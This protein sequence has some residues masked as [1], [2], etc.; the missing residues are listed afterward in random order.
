MGFTFAQ[1]RSSRR[2]RATPRRSGAR[3][4]GQELVVGGLLL[5]Q[6][7]KVPGSGVPSITRGQQVPQTPCSQE[8]GTSTPASARAEITVFPAARAHDPAGA[9]ELH[10]EGPR[11]H[12]MPPPRQRSTPCAPASGQLLAR[13]AFST[14]SISPSART[15][16]GAP[17]WRALQRLDVE[18]PPGAAIV[19]REVHPGREGGRRCAGGT[20][21]AR[22]ACAVSASPELGA[23]S[24]LASRSAMHRMGAA[25]PM[26]PAS[27]RATRVMGE[28]EAVPRG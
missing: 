22:R 28:R 10:I 4:T 17:R 7:G 23:P 11:R 1:G 12:R 2:D 16:T 13:A 14:A 8:Y 9:R 24:S 26:P 3:A 21:C 6:P 5:G 18:R 27:R 15:R 20:P 25:M 19:R